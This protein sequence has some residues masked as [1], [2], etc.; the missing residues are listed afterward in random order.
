MTS[1]EEAL[2]A[3]LAEATIF[4]AALLD[5]CLMPVELRLSLL[6]EMSGVRGQIKDWRSLQKT[7]AVRKRA[8]LGLRG[9]VTPV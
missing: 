6:E 7:L 3:R 2:E 1:S 4:L 5:D 9:E 8:V